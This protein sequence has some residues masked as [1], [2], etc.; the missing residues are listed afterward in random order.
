MFS[1]FVVVGLLRLNCLV[2][3]LGMF[4]CSLWFD[5]FAFVVVVAAVDGG[6]V[7]CTL[8]VLIVLVGTCLDVVFGC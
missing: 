5:W 6:L 2:F 1:Y 4:I 3:G 7:I 8:V